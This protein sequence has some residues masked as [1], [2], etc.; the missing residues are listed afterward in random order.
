MN[1]TPAT[2]SVPPRAASG[3]KALSK[4]VVLQ[5]KAA[6]ELRCSG[7]VE[8]WWGL[9]STETSLRAALFPGAPRLTMRA[10]GDWMMLWRGMR[11]PRVLC[12]IPWVVLGEGRV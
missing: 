12:I 10:L 2:L 8:G 4:A 3:G 11:E 9:R 6:C 7:Q 1:Y 5:R